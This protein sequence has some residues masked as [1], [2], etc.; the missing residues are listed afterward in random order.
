MK[1]WY[2]RK[3]RGR[4]FDVG[5]KVLVILPIVG[6][7]LQARYHDPYTIEHRVNDVDYVVIRR[8][9]RQLCHVNML[10]EYHVED[11]SSDDKSITPVALLATDRNVDLKA[12]DNNLFDDSGIRLNNSQVIS[13]LQSKLGHLS[14][15]QA[16][17]LEILIQNNLVLFPDVPSRT[18][19]VC[20]EVDVGN[21]EPVKQHPYRVN[22]EK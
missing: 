20:H 18:D 2:D 5:D 11:G 19:V 16:A 15:S 10:K 21:A 6:N 9:Q 12:D 3:E 8:K 14:A 7:P 22:P 13:N 1:V 17:D 4:T